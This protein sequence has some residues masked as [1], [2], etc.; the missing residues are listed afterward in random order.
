MYKKNLS[1]IISSR[2]FVAKNSIGVLT[3]PQANVD[4]K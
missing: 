3:I 1:P 2:T 4:E